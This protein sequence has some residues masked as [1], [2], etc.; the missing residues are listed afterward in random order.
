M[1]ILGGWVF[2]MSEVLLYG[3]AEPAHTRTEF[4]SDNFEKTMIRERLVFYCRTTSASTAP[5][6]PRRTCRPYG[7]VNDTGQTYCPGSQP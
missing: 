4:T 2:L 7:F 6:T 5:H 3:G 1:A